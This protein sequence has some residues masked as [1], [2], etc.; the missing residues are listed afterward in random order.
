MQR[1]FICPM[2]L[3]PPRLWLPAAYPAVYRRSYNKWVQ[4]R[5][6][7][8]ITGVSFSSVHE[9]W[10]SHKCHFLALT[11]RSPKSFLL[12]SLPP[13]PAYPSPQ[14]HGDGFSYFFLFIFQPGWK[15]C[16]VT[17]QGAMEW[18]LGMQTLPSV[19]RICFLLELGLQCSVSYQLL[20]LTLWHV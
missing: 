18:R 1:Q 10:E 17:S 15:E 16:S 19:P 12:A 11:D 13:P 2:L 6:R 20:H 14:N 4:R 8:H 3:P 9:H 5:G 7:G